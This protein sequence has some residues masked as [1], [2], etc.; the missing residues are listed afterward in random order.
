MAVPE[1]SR[2]TTDSTIPTLIRTEGSANLPRA[3]VDE[4]VAGPAKPALAAVAITFTLGA[5]TLAATMLRAG[6]LPAALGWS[7]L[8]VM[9]P[10]G[11]RNLMPEAVVTLDGLLAAVVVGWMS[12][13]LWVDSSTDVRSLSPA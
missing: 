10:F 13:L 12:V 11:W 6:R 7:Y 1:R 9:A 2:A 4:L 5:V 8:V 3:V